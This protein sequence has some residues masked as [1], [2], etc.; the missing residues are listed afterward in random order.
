M[1]HPSVVTPSAFAEWRVDK[2]GKSTI[3]ESSQ[4]LVGL[5][6]FEAGQSHALH[7]HS[8]MDKMYYV[9]EG[10]G[11]FL[12]EERE[13]PMTAGQLLIAP[14]GVPHGIR[15]TSNKRLLVL[16]VLA[17]APR[18]TRNNADRGSASVEGGRAERGPRTGVMMTPRTAL[19]LLSSERLADARIKLFVHRMAAEARQSGL[20]P[21]D[22]VVGAATAR[23]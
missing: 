9:I 22:L 1:N 7:S 20:R 17:P 4:L 5:N 13:L 3:Y 23:T 14:D 18:I 15:N 12:L 6:S 10:D 2:M 21:R 11:V 16:A 19:I 8:G